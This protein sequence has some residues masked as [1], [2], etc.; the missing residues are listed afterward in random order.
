MVTKTNDLVN[1]K[2][3]QLRNSWILRSSKS[4]VRYSSTISEKEPYDPPNKNT[5]ANEK[6]RPCHP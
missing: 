5:A 2:I 3:N 1:S 6:P 4:S